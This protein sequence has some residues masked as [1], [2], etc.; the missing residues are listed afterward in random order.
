MAGLFD[1]ESAR[2]IVPG[3]DS[4]KALEE[5]ATPLLIPGYVGATARLL[6]EGGDFLVTEG[7]GFILLEGGTQDAYGPAGYDAARLIVPGANSSLAAVE[8]DEATLI[9]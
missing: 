9:P 2:L 1:A 4:S 3:A 7:G 5:Y 6:A 8:Y